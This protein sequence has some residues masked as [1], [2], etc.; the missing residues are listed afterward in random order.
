MKTSSVS[1]LVAGEQPS[2]TVTGVVVVAMAAASCLLIPGQAVIQK[3]VW[4]VIGLLGLV[5]L[6]TSLRGSLRERRSLGETARFDRIVVWVLV[7]FAFASCYSMLRGLVVG[8]ELGVGIQSLTTTAFVLVDVLVVRWLCV[9]YRM[10]A[11]QVLS[12]VLICSYGI[13]LAITVSKVGMT[14]LAREFG[15]D[16][17][18]NLF[19]SH[20]V[21]VAVIPLLLLYLHRFL[22]RRESL[23]GRRDG[24]LFCLLVIIMLLCHKRSAYLSLAAGV[25][26]LL[27]AWLCRRHAR[28]YALAMGVLGL[29][30][31][32]LYVAAIRLGWVDFLQR[33]FGTVS[34]RYHVWKW[35]DDYYTMSPLSLGMGFG[36]VHRYMEAGLGDTMVNAYN[37]LHNSILQIYIEAGF[38][39]FCI[40]FGALFL[41]LPHA[42]LRWGGSETCLFAVVSVVAMAA[43]FTMDN[44][45]TYPVYQVSFMTSLYGALR[46]ERESGHPARGLSAHGKPRHMRKKELDS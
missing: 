7:P 3:G 10:R 27:V 17:M 42:A 16:G 34:D 29:A 24:I 1:C 46:L 38:A 31:C 22:F 25:L 5:Q 20:D 2:A 15:K 43:M 8:D 44:T 18:R 33:G 4:C 41:V 13:T 9:S 36:F 21:G 23:K 45:L 6:V 35:F 40:W 30:A 32:L 39:G 28:S 37:Y 19:E 14:G 26:A 11:L 12:A